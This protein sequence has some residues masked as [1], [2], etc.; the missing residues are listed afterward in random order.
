MYIFSSP[1]F[2][3]KSVWQIPAN[4]FPSVVA[5]FGTAQIPSM[6]LHQP[7]DV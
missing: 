6:G 5:G 4:G 2:C 1:F 7:Q 3:E